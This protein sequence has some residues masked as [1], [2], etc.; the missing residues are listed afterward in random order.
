MSTISFGGLASGIDTG[1]IISELLEI[2]RRP[3]YRL[4]AT[5]QNYQAQKTATEQLKARVE[6]LRL[7]AADLDD[8]R[9][10]ASLTAISSNEALVSASAGSTAMPGSFDMT[11]NSLAAAQKDMSQGFDSLLTEVGTGLLSI[12]SGGESVSIVLEAGANSLADVRDAINASG[13]AVYATI[14]YDGSETGGYHLVLTAEETGTASTFNVG[15]GG[16][17]GG[18]GLTLNTVTAAANAEVVIDTLTITSQTNTIANAIQGV[19]LDLQSAEPGT[20]LTLDVA[21]DPTLLE[22]Q[23]QSLVD[24]YNDLYSFIETQSA[25]GGILRGNSLLRDVSSQVATWMSSPVTAATGDVVM[26]S[27]VGLSLGDGNQ[28]E[29]ELETFNESVAGDFIA[30]RDL[31]AGIGENEGV[32]D[33]VE[34]MIDAMTDSID[35]RFKLAAEGYDARIENAE[36]SIER[37]ELSVANYETLLSAKFTAMES[38][39]AQLNVQSSYLTQYLGNLNNND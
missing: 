4:E 33:R 13:A 36:D 35:G 39:I 2:K 37:Y 38:M 24:A 29:F 12:G 22:D 7:A 14:M 31:F 10:F 15:A 9:E 6:A 16:L 20:V 30:V 32:M 21:T 26:L 17:S 3:I 34:G 19:T 5:I 8:P 27:Q 1:S 11:V 23:V 28:L 25:E 18:A